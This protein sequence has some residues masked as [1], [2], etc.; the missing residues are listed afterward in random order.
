MRLQVII[1]FI[2]S[3]CWL[4]TSNVC[5]LTE[6]ENACEMVCPA[7][8]Y[9]ASAPS[10]DPD[11]EAAPGHEPEHAH[12]HNFD[13]HDY[14]AE[15]GH[16]HDHGE[17]NETEGTELCCKDFGRVVL[18]SQDYQKLQNPLAHAV[19]YFLAWLV[20]PVLNSIKPD[21]EY[22]DTGPPE[23]G[24]SVDIFLECCFLSNAPPRLI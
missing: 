2:T 12:D 15:H 23:A 16:D 1:T 24:S 21:K 7:D 22:Q 20:A 13:S 4:V 8:D 5:F 17:N 9:Y 10:G 11:C 18:P 14:A 19:S 6:V 3:L